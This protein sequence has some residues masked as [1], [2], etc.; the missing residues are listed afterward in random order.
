MAVCGNSNDWT[1]LVE[2]KRFIAELQENEKFVSSF[3]VKAKT[4]GNTRSGNPFLRIRLGDH[5]GETEGRIWERAPEFDQ[6]FSVNDVVCVHAR[7]ER[8]QGKLQ[9]NISN[10]ERVDPEEVDP[11]DRK[12]VV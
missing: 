3:L 8:Y 12:S 4:L 2:K 9:L 5:T 6:D 7:V 11:T 1:A 10:I